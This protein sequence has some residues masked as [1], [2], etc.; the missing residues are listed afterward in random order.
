MVNGHLIFQ[1]SMGS[2]DCK[3]MSFYSCVQRPHEGF[4]LS[5]C[6]PVLT[7]T[8]DLPLGAAKI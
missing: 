3:E 1:V 5:L 8:G 2:R 6:P 4:C 7:R